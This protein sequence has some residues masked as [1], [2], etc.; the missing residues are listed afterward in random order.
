MTYQEMKMEM[1]SIPEKMYNLELEILNISNEILDKKEFIKNTSTSLLLEITKEVDEKG[2]KL[3]ANQTERESELS[4][5][6]LNESG[7]NEVENSLSILDRKISMKKLE[8]SI[9]RDKLSVYKIL[10]AN[11]SSEAIL[12]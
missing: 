3:Y 9:L 2:K 11:Q 6:L 1:L 10:Y 7:Y 4:K 8:V 12:S 5:R